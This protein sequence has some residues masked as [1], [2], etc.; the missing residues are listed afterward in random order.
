[1]SR[2]NVTTPV[3][4][5]ASVSTTRLD[6]P[7]VI[8]TRL[9]LRPPTNHARSCRMKTVVFRRFQSCCLGCI[10]ICIQIV[11]MNRRCSCCRH[12]RR[13]NGDLHGTTRLLST[14]QGHRAV[15]N[16]SCR[17]H[18]VC[19]RGQQRPRLLN[20]LFGREGCLRQ[21]NLSACSYLCAQHLTLKI[22]RS[23]QT[24]ASTPRTVFQCHRNPS[25]GAQY[26]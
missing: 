25:V 5:A 3:A 12:L 6:M 14:Q 4:V 2:R 26:G 20:N 13:M 17:H 21:Q 8:A 19:R 22:E 16:G 10:Q 15:L 1:M 11:R 24:H 23:I 18:L 7:L 9:S